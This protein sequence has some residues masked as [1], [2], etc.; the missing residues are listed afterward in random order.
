MIMMSTVQTNL[1]ANI[2]LFYRAFMLFK[3]ALPPPHQ[4][5]VSYQ[6]GENRSFKIISLKSAISAKI[7]FL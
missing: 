1:L 3:K 6:K 5:V 4:E 2:L 7:Y